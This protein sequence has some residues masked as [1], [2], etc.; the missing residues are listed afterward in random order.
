MYYRFHL[1]IKDGERATIR[2]TGPNDGLAIA[3][4]IGMVFFFFFS[5]SYSF[6]RFYLTFS[7]Y[8]L[9][10]YFFVCW[11]TLGHIFLLSEKSKLQKN[12]YIQVVPNIVK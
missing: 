5:I 11:L 10:F 12:K 2:E 8:S 1:S 4:A 6:F 3:W 7:F 9:F